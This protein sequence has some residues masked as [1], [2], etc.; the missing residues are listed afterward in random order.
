MGVGVGGWRYPAIP[1]P[2]P[3]PIPHNDR[4]AW[5]PW[6]P[7]GGPGASG[8]VLLWGE[9]GPRPDPAARVGALHPF[10]AERGR[11]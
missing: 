6:L 4:T 10:A 8:S 3:T 9:R 1:A 5:S 2:N 7:D 11:R